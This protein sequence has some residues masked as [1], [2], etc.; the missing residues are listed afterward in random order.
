MKT[1]ISI[2]PEILR[3][4]RRRFEA[5]KS[6]MTFTS[7]GL[8]NETFHM[9]SDETKDET[10]LSASTTEQSMR[11]RLR[12]RETLYLKK[13][14]E[15]LER[16]ASGTF[17]ECEDCGDSIDPRRLE[18]RPTTTLCVGCKEEN[19]RL[20]SMH[21]DGRRHKSAGRAMRFG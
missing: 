6:A 17:G 14:D 21:I 7:L 9:P 5:A 10:D 2:S 12:N 18:A 15:A 13:I 4:F 8:S 16:I 19:E 20:E 1:T 3:N 11:L